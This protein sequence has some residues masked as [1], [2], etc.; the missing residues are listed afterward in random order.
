MI[1]YSLPPTVW[2]LSLCQALLVSGNIVLVTITALIGERIAPSVGLATLPV[3]IQMLGLTSATLPAGWLTARLGR[4]ATFVI[5]NVC[6]L[7]GITLCAQALIQQGFVLFNLGTFLIGASIGTGM[8]YRFAAVDAAP[9]QQ[10]AKALSMVMGGGVLAALFGPWLAVQTHALLET[11]FLG[12]FI[13]LALLYAIALAIIVCVPLRNPVSPTRDTHGRRTRDLMRLPTLMSAV[14]TGTLGYTLMVLIMTATPLAMNH[15][16]FD[17]SD[18]ANVIRWH[19]LAMYA[20]S[21]VTGHLIQRLGYR[22]MIALGGVLLALAAA[23]ALQAPSASAYYAG[24]ILLGLGWNFTFVTASAWLTTTYRPEEAPRAQALNDC[25]VFSGSTLASL[26]AG[27]VNDALGWMAMNLVTLPLCG[28]IVVL[29][30][31]RHSART[32]KSSG[33]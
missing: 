4:R 23:C 6:G 29:V 12:S 26:A 30:L 1:R 33:A 10:R 27:P 3:A 13:G 5:G 11:P 19:V 7:I 17:F 8:L 9:T 21:F 32:P 28:L 22:T 14:V 18:V 20:P 16:Q 25:L 24:L 31:R 15:A 2:W